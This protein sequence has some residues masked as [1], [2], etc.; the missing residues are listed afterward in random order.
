MN[1]WKRILTVAAFAAGAFAQTDTAYVPFI[2]NVNANVT[3]VPASGTDDVVSQVQMSVTAN[4]PA[5]LRIP[6]PKTLGVFN[7]TRRQPNAPAVIGNG[8]GN[9][10]LNLSAQ[11]YKNAEIALYSVNGKRIL[12][13]NVSASSAAKSI[14]RQ[15][16]ATGAYLLSVT[17]TDGAPFASRLTHNGGNLDITLVFGGENR[18]VARQLAKEAAAG[19]WTVTVSAAG[20]VD[21]VYAIKPVKGTMNATQNITLRERGAAAVGTFTDS[22]DGKKYGYVTIGSQTWMAENLNYQ[23]VSGN[24]WCYGNADSNC[25]KYGR[26]YDWSTAKTVCPIGWHLPSEAEWTT[27]AAYAGGSSTAGKKLKSTS[28]WGS[29]S[30]SNGTDE[31][32]FS[33]LPGGFRF[34]GGNFCYAGGNGYWWT[35]TERGS[36]NAYYRLMGYD[37]DGVG[38]LLRQGRRLFCSLSWGLKRGAAG[39]ANRPPPLLAA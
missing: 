3:A 1:L 32:G 34:T 29:S 20:Y 25:V 2:V 39:V 28:G 10:T 9:V 5:T 31:Y 4:T 21:S 27:L 7:D 23:P 37:N 8:G 17:G 12:R 14:S 11:S 13:K 30:I 19:D 22:R 18:S 36:S 24:S 38:E 6:L 35:A 15:N 16:L 26:L 33:A